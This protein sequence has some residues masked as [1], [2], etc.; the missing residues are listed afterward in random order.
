MYVSPY[1]KARLLLYMKDTS[2]LTGD[3][4]NVNAVVV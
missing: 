2:Y 1:F 3:E 4:G